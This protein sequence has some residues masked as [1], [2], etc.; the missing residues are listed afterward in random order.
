MA[1]YMNQLNDKHCKLSK[2]E[3]YPEPARRKAR[4]AGQEPLRGEGIVPRP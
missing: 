3:L 1:F 4:D 2:R